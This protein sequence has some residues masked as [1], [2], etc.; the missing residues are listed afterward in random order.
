M[1][2][3]IVGVMLVCAVVLICIWSLNSAFGMVTVEE[4][5]EFDVEGIEML[6]LQTTAADIEIISSSSELII[7]EIRRENRKEIEK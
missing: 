3:V 6:S 5:K 1:K 2:K 7:G 4:K